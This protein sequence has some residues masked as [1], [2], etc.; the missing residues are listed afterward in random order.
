MARTARASRRVARHVLSDAS[1]ARQ[2]EDCCCRRGSRSA[3]SLAY[4]VILASR[5][6][7]SEWNRINRV[8]DHMRESA[9]GRD[10]VVVLRS[11]FGETLRDSEFRYPIV[12]RMTKVSRERAPRYSRA[13]CSTPANS[14]LPTAPRA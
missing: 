4:L 1:R 6:A 3:W 7:K 12:A 9:A 2:R 5:S 14:R 13:R 11:A 10:H 8:L